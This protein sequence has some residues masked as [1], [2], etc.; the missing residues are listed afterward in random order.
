MKTH[1]PY[2]RLGPLPYL[3]LLI[4]L[5]ACTSSVSGP[6]PV[7]EV[8]LDVHVTGGLAGVDYRL[9]VDGR[10]RLVR[11]ECS[12]ICPPLAAPLAPVVVALS[13]AQWYDLVLEVARSGLPTLGIRDYGSTCC[14]FFHVVVRYEDDRHLSR[15]SGDAETFP[16]ALAALTDRLFALRDGTMPALHAAGSAQG[17]GPDDPLAIDSVSVDGLRIGVGVTYS[18]GCQA[19]EIDM[20]FSG[21]WMESYPVQ[22]TAWLTHEDRDDDCDALPSEVRHFDLSRLA[23]A[24]RTAYPGAPAG[25]RVTVHLTAPGGATGETFEVVL[26]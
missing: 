8:S 18:G 5:T 17:T 12:T 7:G 20:V 6:E 26:P 3:T 14:D 10:D 16:D 2:I 21:D 24:Y 15:A 25:E 19:H 11:L 1:A 23:A 4:G 13:E 9:T 22:T